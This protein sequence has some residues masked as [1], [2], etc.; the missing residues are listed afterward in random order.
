VKLPEREQREV[1]VPPVEVLDAL[2]AALPDRLAAVVPP[3]AGSGLRFSEVAGLEVERV[4]FL[5]RRSREVPVV[6]QLVSPDKGAP[7]LAPVKTKEFRRRVPLAQ[8]T[9][10]ALT[11]HQAAFPAV[12]IEVED[13]LDR[14][15]PQQRTAKLIFT[16]DGVRPLTRNRWS[17][18]WAPAARAAGLPPGTGLHVLRHLYASLL[19][20]HGA[21]V[22]TV[23]K[24]LGHSSAKIT[25]DTYS[26]LWPDAD[27]PGRG[28]GGARS[29]S[30]GLCADSGPGVN[31]SVQVSGLV[32]GHSAGCT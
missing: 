10:D 2:T 16:L 17:A 3:V 24:R 11:A 30:C 21:S 5:L 8:V 19:I 29:R 13:R 1:E 28:R 26:H 9:L 4:D 12:P 18:V 23:Q 20:E 27:D 14:R 22:K 15:R 25:L 32:G 6:Q 31:S 7:F